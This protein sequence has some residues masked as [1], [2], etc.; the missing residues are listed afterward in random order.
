MPNETET[1][2]AKIKM[3]TWQIENL[4]LTTLKVDSSTN[5]PNLIE[6][7]YFFNIILKNNK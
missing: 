1:G 4:N 3:M 2:D 7:N 5:M 6:N